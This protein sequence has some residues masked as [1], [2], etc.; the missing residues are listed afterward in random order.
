MGEQT[1]AE[2]VVKAPS[3]IYGPQGE[4]IILHVDGTTDETSFVPSDEDH[5]LLE[6]FVKSSIGRSLITHFRTAATYDD[7]TRCKLR[8]S[9]E[10]EI[11][12]RLRDI[13]SKGYTGTVS[14][15]FIDLDHFG[16][17]NKKYD[18]AVGDGILVWFASLLRRCTRSHDIIARW[19]GDEFVVFTMSY[20]RDRRRKD[21]SEQEVL[22]EPGPPDDERR[23]ST[24]LSLVR[25]L[26]PAEHQQERNILENGVIV[27]RRIW[28]TATAKS[29]VIS[30]VEI[31]MGVT[32]GVAT[33]IVTPDQVMPPGL[34]KLL[35]SRAA[36]PVE[37]AKN[38]KDSDEGRNMVHQTGMQLAALRT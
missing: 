9:A 23:A 22:A 8:A 14:V 13:Q 36:R 11:E 31:P 21:T 35:L 20:K 38:K 34:F 10:Q 15:L 37:K 32:I 6:R 7:L 24:D 19:G 4:V 18:H 29:C 17:I 26:T 2:I 25:A 33:E 30:G 27:A 28:E 16:D 12:H 5:D 1:T 3:V